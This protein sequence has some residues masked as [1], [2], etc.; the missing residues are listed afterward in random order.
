[1]ISIALK[2]SIGIYVLKHININIVKI[3][4]YIT[5]KI[6]LTCSKVFKQGKGWVS[7]SRSIFEV[8]VFR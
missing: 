3:V 4:N 6:Q 8:I 5:P 2:V 7:I 1:M